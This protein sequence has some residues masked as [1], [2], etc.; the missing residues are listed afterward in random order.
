MLCRQGPSERRSRP[1]L[2]ERKGP[3]AK[4]VGR[5]APTG[6]TAPTAPAGQ[7]CLDDELFPWLTTPI[8]HWPKQ[9]NAAWYCGKLR[10]HST[11]GIAIA[12]HVNTEK[13]SCLARRDKSPLI[14]DHLGN[15]SPVLHIDNQ[16]VSRLNECQEAGSKWG[17]GMS[18]RTVYTYNILTHN[19]LQQKKQ[20]QQMSRGSK[21]IHLLENMTG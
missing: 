15:G 10:C 11:N 19:K 6:R 5:I 21:T 9:K 17:L 2:R 7:P 4:A 18:I 3:A 13:L 8:R 1:R 16:K 14:F 12:R 20:N